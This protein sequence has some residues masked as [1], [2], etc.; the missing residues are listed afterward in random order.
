MRRTSRPY[1]PRKP[2]VAELAAGALIRPPSGRNEVL[3]VHDSRERRWCFPKG[4]VEPG[5]PLFAAAQREVHEETGLR[6]AARPT[7]IGEVHY[8]FYQPRKRRN[9]IKT[10]VYF[11]GR[12]RSARIRLEPGFDRY[13]WASPAEALRLVAYGT[14]REIL[15]LWSGK[16]PR[17]GARRRPAD[18][19]SA[20]KKRR[21]S[22]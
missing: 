7:E 20:K 22:G 14:D 19:F 3:L 10:V 1:R 4:H 6:G 2:S 5:E 17:K 16:S 12:A 9:V 18:A 15:L 21:G 13:R 11:A 8:R